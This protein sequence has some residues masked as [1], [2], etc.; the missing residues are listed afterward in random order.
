MIHVGSLT[1]T[2]TLMLNS[3]VELAKT[4]YSIH[5]WTDDE[6]TAKRADGKIE[7]HDF[8]IDR[9][10]AAGSA[11]LRLES[12]GEIEIVVRPHR[13]MAGRADVSVRGRVPGF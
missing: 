9:A 2:G 5:V 13:I 11:K 6:K 3:E 1:G 4:D 8:A 12:G 10:I 7:T